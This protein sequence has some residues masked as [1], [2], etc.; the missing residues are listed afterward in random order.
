MNELSTPKKKS[1]GRHPDASAGSP[2]QAKPQKSRGR[3]KLPWDPF[4]EELYRRLVAGEA[5]PTMQQEAQA[6]A[7]WARENGISTV[8]G[9]PA[10]ALGADRIRQRISKRYKGAHGYIQARE[11]H[12]LIKRRADALAEINTD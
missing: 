8:I 3:P 4:E 1:A 2:Q 9:N 12:L 7:K 5:E 6:L 11:H 10:G